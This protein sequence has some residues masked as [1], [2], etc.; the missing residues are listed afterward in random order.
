MKLSELKVLK[1]KAY[2]LRACMY[3][4]IGLE[5]TPNVLSPGNRVRRDRMKELADE[6]EWAKIT[7]R[8]W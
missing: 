5:Y 7:T 8:F 2:Y 1:G 6:E 4:L 3:R